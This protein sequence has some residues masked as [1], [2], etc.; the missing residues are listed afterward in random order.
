MG[1]PQE[2]AAAAPPTA[3]AMGAIEV[4][5]PTGPLKPPWRDAH[6]SRE[7]AR[8][9]RLIAEADLCGDV[10]EGLPAE[11]ALARSLQASAKDVRMRRD[12]EDRGERA[13]E[14]R[15]A[16]ANGSRRGG[17]GDAL[18]QVRVQESPHALRLIRGRHER[19]VGTRLAE[20][21]RDPFDD[22]REPRLGFELAIGA[23]ERIV[24]RGDLRPEAGV[25]NDRPIDGGTDDA[26]T[27]DVRLQVQH[28]LTK[29]PACGPAAV[30]DHLRREDRHH[31]RLGAA[32]PPVEVIAD[33][34]VV[35]D[36][37]RPHVV[38]VRRVRVVGESRVEHLT[39]AG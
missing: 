10:G 12:P 35:D 36:E 29:A 38:D 24:E 11:E 8:E 31:G 2:R 34:P 5:R 22:E 1:P 21:G 28:P 30:M 26:L 9:V 6:V 37:Q 14:L 23:G 27:E 7:A 13:R 16:S 32:V 17:D 39:D 25:R 19:P 3:E 20:R 15:G 33:R 18:E 4:S